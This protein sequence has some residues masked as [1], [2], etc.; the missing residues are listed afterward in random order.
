MPINKTV[1]YHDTDAGG[2]VYYGRYLNFLEEAR[3]VFLD[4]IG[5]N[6]KTLNDQGFVF[7]VR[8]CDLTYKAPARYGDVLTCTAEVRAV[9]PARIVF[10]QQV[11]KTSSQDILVEASVEMVCVNT[12]FKPT[13]MPRAL[14]TTLQQRVVHE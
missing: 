2:V 9:T 4:D 10:K 6:V 11:L 12:A 5:F 14:L 8:H 13:A 7:A 3:T 1:F